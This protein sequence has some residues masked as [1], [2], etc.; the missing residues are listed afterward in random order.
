MRRGHRRKVALKGILAMGTCHAFASS[1]PLVSHTLTRNFHVLVYYTYR[2][3]AYRTNQGYSDQC[4]S[5]PPRWLTLSR[6]LFEEV[7][8]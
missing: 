7:I 6:Y 8:I 2:H 5:S 3:Q 4:K 1:E